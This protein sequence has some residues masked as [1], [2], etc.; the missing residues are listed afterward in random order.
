MRVNGQVTSSHT[1]E[2]TA[3]VSDRPS[4]AYVDQRVSGGVAVATLIDLDF[5]SSSTATSGLQ[6]LCVYHL[7]L[8]SVC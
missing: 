8:S 4:P 2:P 1:R 6:A 5:G 3:A 7:Y